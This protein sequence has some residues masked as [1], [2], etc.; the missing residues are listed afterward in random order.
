MLPHPICFGDAQRRHKKAKADPALQ[1]QINHCA[2][3]PD[4][5]LIASAGWDN[6]VKIW[7]AK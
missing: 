4:G 3:S 5:N 6:H 7:S 2:F 1:K